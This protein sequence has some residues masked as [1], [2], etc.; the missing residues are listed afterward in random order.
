MT[1][2]RALLASGILALLVACS[3]PLPA[4]RAAYVGEWEGTGMVLEIDHDGQVYYERMSNGSRRSVNMP[5]IRFEGA[6]FVVGF[7]PFTTTFIV[8]SPPHE[9]NGAWLMTVDGVELTRH[10]G[11]ES[12]AKTTTALRPDA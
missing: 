1:A 9:S 10:S 11:T 2:A 4:D 6:N 8:S 5:L 12:N 7:G 3:S